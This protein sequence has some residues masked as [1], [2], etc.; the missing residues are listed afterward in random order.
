MANNICVLLGARIRELRKKRRWRQLDLAEHAKLNENYISD[1]EIGKKEICLKSL[2]A[3]AK[4]FDLKI[5][6]LMRGVEK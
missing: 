2:Q 3:I 4:A 5:D 6:E 1:L